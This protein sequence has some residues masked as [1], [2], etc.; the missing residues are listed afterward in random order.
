MSPASGTRFAFYGRVS[1]E[2]HQDPDP[3]RAWQMLRAQALVSRH[4]RIVAEFFDTGRSRTIPWARRPEAA[5]LLAAMADPDPDFDAL[6]IG[7]SERAFYRP[8]VNGLRPSKNG[9]EWNFDF[10][11]SIFGQALRRIHVFRHNKCCSV[12]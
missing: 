7:S 5:A 2:D 10:L 8:N 3:S 9:G 4:G 1:T 12:K 11:S 6:V